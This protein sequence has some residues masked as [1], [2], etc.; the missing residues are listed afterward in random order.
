MVILCLYER[1]GKK[2]KAYKYLDLVAIG[3]VADIV[4]LV[5][6]NRILTKFGLEQLSRSKNKGLR[7]CCINCLVRKIQI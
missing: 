7:F 1:I 6:E 3:T 5:E 2:A 4:P